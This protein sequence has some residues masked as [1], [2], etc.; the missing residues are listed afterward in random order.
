MVERVAILGGTGKMGQWFAQFFKNIGYEVV[1]GGRYREKNE[2]VAKEIGV[3]AAASN[4]DAVRGAN[5]VIVST[6]LEAVVDTIHQIKDC[7]EKG[8]IVFDIAS[9]K[10]G[11]PEALRELAVRGA[12]VISTHPL[13]GA[14]ADSFIGRKMIIIP[15]TDDGFLT[16]WA[17]NLFRNEGAEV[18]VVKDSEEHDRFVAI[19]LGLTHFLNIVFGRALAKH[20][21]QE[22]KKFAG[23]TF[24]LQLTLVEAVLSEDPE[25]YYSIESFNPAFKNLLDEFKLTIQKITDALRNKE[26]FV[27]EFEEARNSLS[28]DPKFQTAY[29]RFYKAVKASV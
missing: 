6:A 19:T 1:I 21:I 29:K 7:V 13:F 27:R 25:L 17:V 23:T 16:E 10:D 26:D 14:G 12:R 22:I 9:V 15:I 5:I 20:D 24:S 11:I 4:I 28:K 18:Y 8:T 3:V 2:A